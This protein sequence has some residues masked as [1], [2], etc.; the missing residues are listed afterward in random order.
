VPTPSRTSRE[1]IVAAGRALV[2][3]GGLDALTMHRV[4]ATVGV[5][6]P[7][8]YKHVPSRGALIKLIVEDVVD[9]LAAALDGRGR[10]ATPGDDLGAVARAFRL[11]A[12]QHPG[13]YRLIFAPLPEEWRAD[14]VHLMAAS[15]AVLT[16]AAALAGQDR[17]LEAARTI[18]A[19]AHGFVAMEL[20][21]A[22]RMGGDVDQAFEFG[23]D[24]LAGAF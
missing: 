11:F 2:E 20:A 18:T 19:W 15:R 16:I 6:P 24:H 13:T 1:E 4:A 10:A 22:F 7:S 3:A 9:D 14:P 8:L 5:R 12:K 17:S 23:I 21:D